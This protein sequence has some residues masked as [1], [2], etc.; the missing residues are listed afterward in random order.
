M[1]QII[2]KASLPDPTEVIEPLRPAA[3]QAQSIVLR[4]PRPAGFPLL[5]TAQWQLIEPAVAF[6]HEHFV[7]R[8]HTADTVRTYA[9]ILYDW[10]ETL[11]QNAIGQEHRTTTKDISAGGASI[12]ADNQMPNN[13][14]L[15]MKIELPDGGMVIQCLSRVERSEEIKKDTIYEVAVL[16]MDMSRADKTRIDKFVKA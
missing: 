7:Q 1:V 8:A 16:F 13:T 12:F 4:E 2:R 9:E 15:D 6:L 14:K 10:F 5:F 3:E 11:E